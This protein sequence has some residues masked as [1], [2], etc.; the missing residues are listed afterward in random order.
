M[1][2][3]DPQPPQ[4]RPI[5]TARWLLMLVPSVPMLLAPQIVKVWTDSHDPRT[6]EGMLAKVLGLFAFHFTIAMVLSIVMGLLLEKWRYGAVQNLSRAIGSGASI[7][8]TN[9]FIAWAGCT[10]IT[11]L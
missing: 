3:P 10:A 6:T 4:P 5:S 1:S 8:F 9:F 11:H 2:E 7:L